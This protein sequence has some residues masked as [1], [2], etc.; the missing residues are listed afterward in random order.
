MVEI[1]QHEHTREQLEE[2]HKKD[3][4]SFSI[5][6]EKRVLTRSNFTDII[7]VY[8][9][10]ITIM[11]FHGENISRTASSENPFVTYFENEIDG[12]A[13]AQK[14]EFFN[15]SVIAASNRH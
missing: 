10:L 9:P 6:Y 12:S 8:K 7:N 5:K 14:S 15:R 2:L 1:A 3:E 11:S 4:L 13:D